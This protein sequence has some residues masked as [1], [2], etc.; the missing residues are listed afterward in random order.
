MIRELA[1][2]YDLDGLE[3]DFARGPITLTLGQQWKNRRHL[4]DFMRA[5]RR[6]T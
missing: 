1:E 6:M 2:N 5:V 4:T 3:M